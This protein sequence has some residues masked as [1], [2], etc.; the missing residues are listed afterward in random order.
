M[1][2]AEDEQLP[3]IPREIRVVGAEQAE[4]LR[5]HL[6][7]IDDLEPGQV[8]HDDHRRAPFV[9]DI[10]F[11]LA[12]GDAFKRGVPVGAEIIPDRTP[13]NGQP[14]DPARLGIATQDPAVGL[15]TNVEPPLGVLRDSFAIIA[16]KFLRRERGQLRFRETIGE[17]HHIRRRAVRQQLNAVRGRAEII[18][19]EQIARRRQQQSGRVKPLAAG[20]I[21]LRR[22]LGV[23][24]I[25]G[26]VG[27]GLLG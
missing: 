13:I 17:R 23:Q 21:Q 27:L 20:K 14:L 22:Q 26:P 16:P 18:H 4:P 7:V 9:G 2:P 19:R 11:S 3:I 6:E 1:L 15:L 12:D 8:H 10:E 25:P 24:H 5:V